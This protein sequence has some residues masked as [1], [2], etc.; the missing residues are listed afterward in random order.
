MPHEPDSLH[1]NNQNKNEYLQALRAVGSILQYYDSDKEIPSYGF[2]AVVAGINRPAH[3]FAL[4][5]D[6]FA[7]EC[8][9]IDGVEQA[10]QNAIKNVKLH[11]PTYFNDIISTINGRCEASEVSAY[12]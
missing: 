3:C 2:G 8:N 5:G 7:P 9:G 4:N 12:N 11:G 6:I 10:Y 1:S